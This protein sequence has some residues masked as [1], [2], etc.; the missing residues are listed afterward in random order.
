MNVDPREIYDVISVAI[1]KDIDW[2]LV[3]ASR[4]PDLAIILFPGMEHLTGFFSV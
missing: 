2:N 1:A 4:A 3:R